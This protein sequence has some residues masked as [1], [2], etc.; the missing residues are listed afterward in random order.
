[1]PVLIS[2][3]AVGFL[4]WYTFDADKFKAIQ[5]DGRAWL[6]IFASFLLLL[7]RH[8]SYA[9]RLRA[10]TD[11][12]LS[13][14]NYLK[15]VVMWEFSSAITP[16]SKGG[17]FVMMFAL[18]KEG[19]SVGRSTAAIMYTMALDAGFFVTMLPLMLSLFGS[20]MIFPEK[21]GSGL[22]SGV[23][24]TTYTLMA[25]Y[26]ICFMVFLFFRPELLRRILR[27]LSRM[28]FFK[29][30]GSGMY[31]LGDDFVVSAKEIK[32]QP[33]S[34]HLTAIV[35]TVGAWTSKFLMINCIML[36]VWPELPL[37]GQ[38]Q[39]FVFARLV[40]M[41]IV[42]AFSFTPG[43]AG[44]AEIGLVTFI[45]DFVPTTIGTV[46]ALIWRGMAFWGYLLAGAFI[47]P[48][49]LSEKLGAQTVENLKG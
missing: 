27:F 38:T 48:R 25:A 8:F 36:G 46:V 18:P 32:A 21:V 12:V 28:P 9:L 41:F 10:L 13:W 34:V 5:W 1:M 20:D 24:F 2:V 30:Y 19:I 33:F 11:K 31:H 43:G 47:V 3:C 4:F 6:W 29:K 45:S 15:L 40:A 39:A 7:L 42:L 35:G 14:T 49:W 22:A 37:D 17:P 16:T 26:W 23:F 44:L